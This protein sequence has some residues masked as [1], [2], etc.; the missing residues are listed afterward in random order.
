MSQKRYI[1]FGA[2][3]N[4]DDLNDSR[5]QYIAPTVLSGG[6]FVAAD[7]K[8]RIA[9]TSLAL[10]SGIIVTEDQYK[11][12]TLSGVPGDVSKNFTIVYSHDDQDV[13]NG[14]AAILEV[15]NDLLAQSSLS[16]ATII[17]WVTYPGGGV[18]LSSE[19]F[20]QTRPVKLG[21]EITKYDNAI[22]GVKVPPLSSK[23][24]KAS[25]SSSLI[26]ISDIYDNSNPNFIKVYT[27]FKNSSTFDAQAICTFSFMVGEYPP[28]RILMNL[29]GSVDSNIIIDIIDETGVVVDVNNNTWQGTGLS[30]FVDRE[31]TFAQ[32]YPSLFRQGSVFVVRLIII[33]N[34]NTEMWLKSIGYTTYNLPH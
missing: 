8:L 30:S 13:I 3:M 33:L 6:V 22:L 7:N 26:V 11:T 27:R 4:A 5:K 14:T 28:G 29:T 23:L 15:Y 25:T 12:L 16:N 34:A 18:A 24:V 31:F 2:D 32:S 19:H 1:N 21:T 20:I 9:S 17:G 10:P